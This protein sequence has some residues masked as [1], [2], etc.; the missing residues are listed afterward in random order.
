MPKFR[1]A[2]ALSVE[3]LWELGEKTAMRAYC[4]QLA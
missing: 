2:S 4:D 3:F 1:Y